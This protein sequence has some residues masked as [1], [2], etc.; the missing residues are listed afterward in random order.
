M[1]KLFWIVEEYECSH[2]D[3]SQA[4]YNI[5]VRVVSDIQTLVFRLEFV[6]PLQHGRS[7]CK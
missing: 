7:C 5:H 4:I 6:Y 1:I 3:I 2:H